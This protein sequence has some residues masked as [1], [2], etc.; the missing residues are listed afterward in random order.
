MVRSTRCG[1]SS[2]GVCTSS[3]C[4]LPL[5]WLFRLLYVLG[6][7]RLMYIPR[8]PLHHIFLTPKSPISFLDIHSSFTWFFH[9]CIVCRGVIVSVESNLFFGPSQSS[10]VPSIYVCPSRGIIGSS[11]VLAACCSPPNLLLHLCYPHRFLLSL[12]AAMVPLPIPLLRVSYISPSHLANFHHGFNISIIPILRP[13]H[14]H[15]EPSGPQ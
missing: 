3:T 1:I 4:L 8:Y 6:D 5:V 10:L 9:L 12:I 11:F 2:G 15:P 14:R 13:Q 7:A